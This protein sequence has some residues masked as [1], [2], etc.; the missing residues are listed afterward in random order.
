LR[1]GYFVFGSTAASV[2]LPINYN[3]AT[4]HVA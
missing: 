4:S 3:N 1:V 2:R